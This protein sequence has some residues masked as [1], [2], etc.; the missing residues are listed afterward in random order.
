MTNPV[1]RLRNILPSD[2]TPISTLEA[3]AF[4]VDSWDEDDF[5][6]TAKR[7]TSVLRVAAQKER[8]I[9]YSMC[10]RWSRRYHIGSV[11][12]AAD[13]Q[14]KGIGLRLMRDSLRTA[15][16]LGYEVVSLEV[17]TTNEPAI[18]MY[19]KLG[20][21]QTGERKNYYYDGG[22]ALVMKRYL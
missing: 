5:R 21:K 14:G 13:Q 15:R 1:V 6:L 2:F 17:K 7:K 8:L 20:F 12:V 9:G 3:E 10:F 18:C 22:N 19:K 16:Q 11:A 4:G